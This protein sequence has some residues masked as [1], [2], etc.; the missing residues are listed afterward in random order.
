MPKIQQNGNKKREKKSE[1]MKPKRLNE[2]NTLANENDNN[3][4]SE[5]T[6]SENESARE[7]DLRNIVCENQNDGYMNE[8]TTPEKESDE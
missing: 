1:E 8:S 6:R 4:S 3:V 7:S 5:L 2:D